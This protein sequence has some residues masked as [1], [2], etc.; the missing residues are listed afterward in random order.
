M[1]VLMQKAFIKVVALIYLIHNIRIVS[2][3]SSDIKIFTRNKELLIMFKFVLPHNPIVI[4]ISLVIL[5]EPRHQ[6]NHHLLSTLFNKI[7]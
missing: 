7:Y 4:S 1:K 3:L 6:P 2:L 5:S